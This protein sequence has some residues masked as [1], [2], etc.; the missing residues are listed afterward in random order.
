MIRRV[1]L[2]CD[3]SLDCLCGLFTAIITAPAKH[4]IEVC[5]IRRMGDSRSGC[6]NRY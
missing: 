5:R 6:S 2:V 3:D 4:W 1:E